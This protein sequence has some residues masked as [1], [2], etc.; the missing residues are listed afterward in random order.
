MLSYVK[1]NL[2]ESPAHVLV[3]TVNTVGI[4]GKGIAKTFK[5]VYPDM[6][7]T[8]QL[9]C[10]QRKIDVGK[11]WLYKTS[12]KWI[13]HFP[14]KK[15]WRSPSKPEYI[16]QGLESFRKNYA[17]LG[18]TS[19]AFPPLGC[20]NGELDWEMQVRPIMEEYLQDLPIDIFIYLYWG[21]SDNKPE[22]K[23]IKEIKKWLRSE[24][25]SL[26]FIEVWEDLKSIIGNGIELKSRI[27]NALVAYRLSIS[28]DKEEDSL[29]Y[30]DSSNDKHAISYDEWV[31]IW[32]VLR[33]YGFVTEKIIPYDYNKIY[34]EIITLLLRLNYCQEVIINRNYTKLNSTSIGIQLNELNVPQKQIKQ[35]EMLF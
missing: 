19:V 3:N 32:S 10:E 29:I 26:G 31:D 18:I 27:N 14:S 8:Y 28:Q 2:F 25:K 13:L 23:N 5:S 7:K 30:V 21:D 16:K 33:N 12:N 24:P 4:M 15:H 6:F 1:G 35:L 17:D 20:G 9:L 11:L 22:H 34:D